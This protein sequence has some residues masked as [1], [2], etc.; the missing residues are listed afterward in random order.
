MLSYTSMCG[1]NAMFW[2]TIEIPRSFGGSRVTSRSPMFTVPSVGLVSPAIV[3][4]V[5]DFPHPEGPTSVTNSPSLMSR[6]IPSTAV[7][8]S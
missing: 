8:S 1:N 3:S 7:T 4:I 5:V 6:S 2:N